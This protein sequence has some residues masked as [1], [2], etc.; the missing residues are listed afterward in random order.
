MGSRAILLLLGIVLLFGA[1]RQVAADEIG[2]AV[3][4][5]TTKGGV[6]QQQ[7]DAL[8]DLLAHSI[9]EQG[10]YRVLGKADISS[11]L[12][13][14]EQK[15]LLGC[16]EASCL[17]ELGGALGVRWV[18]VGN[19]A[20]FGDMFLL[21]LKMVDSQ[22]A[23]VAASVSEKV[24]GGP[25]DLVDALPKAVRVLFERAGSDLRAG[26]QK[27]DPNPS[28]KGTPGVASAAAVRPLSTWGHVTFWS[29]LGL[30]A[31]GGVAIWQAE[32]ASD[33]WVASGSSTYAD[34]HRTWNGVAYT[35]FGL[36]GALLVTGAVLWI[37]DAGEPVSDGAIVSGGPT[38]DGHGFGLSVGGRW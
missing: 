31:L 2:I 15:A 26:V 19:S 1:A 10:P 3:M 9:R 38:P 34:S 28:P 32:R 20:K 27:A 14:E 22:L 5:F 7:M 11:L 33:N 35:A 23:R 13:V 25:E 37:M 8:G 16:D 24:S 30:S 6:T 18:V 29:G 4:E 17:A 21:N 36:G 12:Q